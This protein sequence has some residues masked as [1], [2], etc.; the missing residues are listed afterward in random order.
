V[1][2]KAYLFCGQMDLAD[3]VS[4]VRSEVFTA[5]TMKKAV[6][7]NVAPCRCVVNRR[8]GERI[9]S[10]YLFFMKNASLDELF[11]T[12]GLWES[13]SEPI[14]VKKVKVVSVFN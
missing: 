9:A 1:G 11:E 14:N 6:F 12:C 10:I 4:L 7:W 2:S 13:K 3:I 8:F 5:V